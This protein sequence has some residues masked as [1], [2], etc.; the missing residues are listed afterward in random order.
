M[1][2]SDL[3]LTALSN[4]WQRKTRTLLT[5][6]GVVIG[7]MSI[8]MMLALGEGSQRMFMQQVSQSTDLTR[9][10][11]SPTYSGSKT[12]SIDEKIVTQL[13]QLA[14][15]RMVVPLSQ[16]PVYLKSQRYVGQFYAQAVPAEKLRQMGIKLEWGSFPSKGRN[17]Q[18]LLGYNAAQDFRKRKGN[19]NLWELPQAQSP[20][21]DGERFE[22]YFGDSNYYEQPDDSTLGEGVVLPKA[23]DGSVSGVALRTDGERDYQSYVTLEAV[24]D[25]VKNN[26]KAA[27]AMGISGKIQSVQVYATDMNTV[28]ALTAQIKELGFQASSPMEYI[29]QM[30]KESQRQAAQWGAVGAIALLV[31]AI[32]IAN[33]MLTSI[34]ERKREIGVLKV[35]GC[36]L[37]QIQG[38]FLIESGMIGMLGGLL[39]VALSFAASFALTQLPI[40]GTF[41]GTFIGDGGLNFV[42]TPV[43]ALCAV[44]GAML[45]GMAAG[46]YPAMRAMRMSPLSA[47]RDE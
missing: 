41:L 4:L 37:G 8:V 39:G 45:V 17:V 16:V 42:I 12:T 14:N 7:T 11:V 5:V 24:A 25:F 30:Q 34:M 33:T 38:M 9:I 44:A 43:M 18:V 1:K 29:K 2:I 20:A 26:K 3:V 28:E 46:V 32:G 19:K 10:E 31:S 27:E 6:L 22:L 21:L 35:L 47:L 36:G 13:E 15:V 23:V 40:Q